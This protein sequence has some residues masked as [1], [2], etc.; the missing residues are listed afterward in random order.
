MPLS[1]LVSFLSRFVTYLLTFSRNNN[2]NVLCSIATYLL[3]DLIAT[4]HISLAMMLYYC[5]KYVKAVTKRFY[6]F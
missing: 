4:L 1:P 6:V 5:T 3:S 2:N